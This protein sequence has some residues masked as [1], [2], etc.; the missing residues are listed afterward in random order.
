MMEIIKLIKEGNGNDEQGKC[1]TDE[2]E[3]EPAINDADVTRVVEK[4]I[5]QDENE[6]GQ[7]VRTV[8]L[9]LCVDTPSTLV[10]RQLL[11]Q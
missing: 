7:I 3:E 2:N 10:Q 4:N 8:E 6:E 11:Y 1:V 9:V 5:E